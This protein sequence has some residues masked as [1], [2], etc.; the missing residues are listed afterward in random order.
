MAYEV[1]RTEERRYTVLDDPVDPAIDV[2]RA[3]TKRSDSRLG[4]RR[5]ASASSLYAGWKRLRRLMML[6]NPFVALMT[7]EQELHL[8]SPGGSEVVRTR[9]TRRFSIFMVLLRMV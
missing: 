9:T 2:V 3:S 4:L 5:A 1:A 6:V 8:K 7:F